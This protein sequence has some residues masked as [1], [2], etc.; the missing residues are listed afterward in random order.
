MKLEESVDIQADRVRVWLA[1]SDF[2]RESE[3]WQGIKEVKVLFKDNNTMVR[4]VIQY[5]MNSRSLQKVII[6][7]KNSI[8]YFYLQG[9]MKGTKVLFIEPIKETLTRLNAAWHVRLSWRLALLSPIIKRHIREGTRNALRRIKAACE[10]SE[11]KVT[12]IE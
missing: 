9:P 4:E 7:P 8:E 6:H 10:E 3:Y 11:K 1:I 2:S 5:F 12:E